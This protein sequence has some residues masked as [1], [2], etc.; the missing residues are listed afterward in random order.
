[1]RPELMLQYVHF[2]RDSY[3]THG[4]RDVAIYAD[5]FVSL[6]YR[7]MRRFID[8]EVDLAQVE[9]SLRS[10]H[11]VLPD[12]GDPLPSPARK[13]KPGLHKVA[14]QAQAFLRRNRTVG[15]LQ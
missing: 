14:D 15:S 11:W 5:S 2:L 4:G 13:L 8:P 10:A 7:P 12:P 1:S 6:N 9:S 3:A